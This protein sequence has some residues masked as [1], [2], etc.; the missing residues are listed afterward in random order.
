MEGTSDRER[1]RSRALVI[2]LVD[3]FADEHASQVRQ[4]ELIA[5]LCAAYSAVDAVGPVLPGRERMVPAGA[6]G[7]P[8]VAEH[9]A[10]EIA[11]KLPM[12]IESAGGLIAESMNVLYRHP[13]LWEATRAARV[14]VWQARQIASAVASAG[15]SAEAAAWVDENL[16]PALGHLAWGRVRR[17]LAGLITRADVE[18]AARRAARARA[19][20]HVRVKQNGDGTAWFMART[21]AAEAVRLAHTIDQLADQLALGGD[22]DE[23]DVRRARALGVLA[24]SAAALTL[25]E[26]PD[27]PPR[28]RRRGTAELIIHFAPGEPVGRC[29]QL[30]PVLA[31]QVKEWLGHDRVV[32]RPVIDLAA[33]PAVDDYEIPE[34]IARIVR[35]RHP[36]D[37]F[38]WASRVSAGLDQDHTRPYRRGPDKPRGQTCP[39]NLAPLSR[40]PHRAKTHAGWRVTRRGACE[41]IW[42]SPLGFRYRVDRTGS[43]EL[44]PEPP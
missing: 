15:L 41:F 14:R 7:T 20:R 10:T 25:L 39:D 5:E 23:A 4:V 34:A 42:T 27:V 3:A 44:P 43:H 11:P 28:R 38:P 31:Q 26:G 1:S 30:G 37:V 13:R 24:D 2:G 33:N 29:E 36:H 40:R 16:E 12:S 6:D 17:K 19:E 9:V 22:T 8:L 18:L 21:D 35:L 32:V